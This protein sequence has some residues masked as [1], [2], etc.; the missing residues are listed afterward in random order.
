MFSWPVILSHFQVETM[1]SLVTISFQAS[2]HFFRIS[3]CQMSLQRPQRF[4]L[5]V[6]LRWCVPA[7]VHWRDLSWLQLLPLG[8][9]FKAFCLSLR[10]S[11]DYRCVPPGQA[12]FCI[13]SRD[14]VSPCWPGWSQTPKLRWF[15][16]LGL[17]KCW[18]YRH[19]PPHLA[20]MENFFSWKHYQRVYLLRAQNFKR[21]EYRYTS[22]DIP[23]AREVVI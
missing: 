18:D 19:E 10:S 21:P 1:W 8:S 20:K 23:Q 11:W 3:L 2:F 12:H 4:C 17:P 5:F 16:H 22:S 14:R 9:W 15:A 13:V 7:G 6:C